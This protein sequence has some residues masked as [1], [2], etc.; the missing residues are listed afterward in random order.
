MTQQI[1]LQATEEIWVTCV[2]SLLWPSRCE[3]YY[4]ALLNHPFAAAAVEVADVVAETPREIVCRSSQGHGGRSVQRGP[5]E[6]RR[7]PS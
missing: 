7:G 5:V 4:K 6:F 1:N 3:D 2:G